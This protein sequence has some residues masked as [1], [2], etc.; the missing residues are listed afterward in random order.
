MKSADIDLFEKLNAQ[1]DGLHQEIS[2][3]TRKSPNDAVN[4]FKLGLIN[5]ILEKCNELLGDDFR[6]FS[7]FS[8]FQLDAMP[9]NSDVNFI[10]SQYI[11]CAEQFRSDNI[12]V[13]NG[14]WFWRVE[15]SDDE[16]R[17]TNIPK[18]FGKK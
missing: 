5:T 2:T 3:L 7:D 15:D 11:E 13:K 4:A 18:R 16:T 10:L 1:L 14:A 17:R 9:S 6:P 8:V 12:F